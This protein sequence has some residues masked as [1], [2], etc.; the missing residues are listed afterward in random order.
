M[1]ANSRGPDS[2]AHTIRSLGSSI[3]AVTAQDALRADVVILAVPFSAIPALVDEAPPWTGR[4]V[5]DASNAYHFPAFTPTDLGGR[6]SSDVVADVVAGARVVKAFNTVPA[7]ILATDPNQ[8]SGRRVITLSG[9]D[10]TA[11]H[12]V[13]ELIEHLGFAAIDLGSLEQGSR[14]QQPLGALHEVNLIRIP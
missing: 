11:N 1:V 10:Q 2:L 14:L 3:T 7:K 6:L 5:I 9:N 4:I 12:A 13:A 8:S